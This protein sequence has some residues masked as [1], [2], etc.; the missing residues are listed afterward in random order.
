MNV[1]VSC[2]NV[3]ITSFRRCIMVSRS[4]AADTHIILH[5]R[6]VS[7]HAFIQQVGSASG[8]CA[9]CAEFVSHFGEVKV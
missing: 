5:E 4:I 1:S 7:S 2:Y 6:I 8:E 3:V 9:S